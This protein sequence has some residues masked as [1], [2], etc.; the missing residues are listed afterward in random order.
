MEYIRSSAIICFNMWAEQPFPEALGLHLQAWPLQW[1]QEHEEFLAVVWVWGVEF[2]S[3]M[4][5]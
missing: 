5:V 2:G 4:G 3:L 1:V